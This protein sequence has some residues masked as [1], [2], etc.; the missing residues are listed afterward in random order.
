[1]QWSKL[2]MT[3]AA[4]TGVA[5]VSGQVTAKSLRT[6]W[7]ATLRRPPWQPPAQAFGP[8]WTTLYC[9][10]AW[11][12]AIVFS[13]DGEEARQAGRLWGVQLALNFLW[14]L[15]FFGKRWLGGSV[16]CIALLWAS[17]LAYIFT[18]RKVS[19]LAS[20]LFAPYTAWVTFAA[21]INLWV[22]RHNRR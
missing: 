22:W 10:I 20:A 1:M 11:S 15:L 21:S 9:L 14:S 17:I 19:G 8:V 7:Y 2:A 16:A 5:V 12:G 4:V 13:R 3:A 6:P 18:A